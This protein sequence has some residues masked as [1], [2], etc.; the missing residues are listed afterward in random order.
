MEKPKK[1]SHG[2]I[3]ALDLKPGLPKL[4]VFHMKK[5]QEKRSFFFFFFSFLLKSSSLI[6]KPGLFYRCK[7]YNPFRSSLKKK[8]LSSDFSVRG[9]PSPL[10]PSWD[11]SPP[12]H[13]VFSLQYKIPR[14]DCANDCQGEGTCS[15]ELNSKSVQWTV[16]ILTMTVT[17]PRKSWKSELE[18]GHILKKKAQHCL[19]ERE[20]LSENK[21]PHNWNSR[22]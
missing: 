4:L 1:S 20:L 10:W 3:C 13:T 2:V 7:F 19:W 14:M 11:W 17:E 5:T 12:S 16:H 8:L 6:W 22:T 15:T 9:S 18:C 21:F